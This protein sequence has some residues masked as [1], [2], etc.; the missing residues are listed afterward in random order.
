MLAVDAF[1]V[2]PWG[3]GYDET[4]C[5]ATC[6]EGAETILDVMGQDSDTSTG[7]SA[8]VLVFHVYSE[9]LKSKTTLVTA[10]LL[11]NRL[12]QVPAGH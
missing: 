7:F 3:P 6:L 10:Y 1:V 8:P 2:E 9:R 11:S 4:P 12:D 5:T